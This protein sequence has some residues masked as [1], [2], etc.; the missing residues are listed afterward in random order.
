MGRRRARPPPRQTPVFSFSKISMNLREATTAVKGK[1]I[2]AKEQAAR[3]QQRA[4]DAEA[5]LAAQK[6]RADSAEGKIVDLILRL[7]AKEVR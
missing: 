4:A 2:H 6:L 1:L 7:N 3:T 5:E